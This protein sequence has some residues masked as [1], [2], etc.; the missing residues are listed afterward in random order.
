MADNRTT[1]AP[2][3]YAK[4]AEETELIKAGLE[5]K[6]AQVRAQLNRMLKDVPERAAIMQ[7]FERFAHWH[8]AHAEVSA[9][10]DRYIAGQA[11]QANVEQENG[12]TE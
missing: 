11:R 12:S 10:L 2:T 4:L 1:K 7:N 3:N 9:R 8:G 6:L 5:M